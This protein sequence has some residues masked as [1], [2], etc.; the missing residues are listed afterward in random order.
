MKYLLFIIVIIPYFI[1]AQTKVEGIIEI[2]DSVLSNATIIVKTINNEIIT[3]DVSDEDGKFELFLKKGEY[4]IQVD[5][6][7]FKEWQKKIDLKENLNLGVI[8][9]IEDE[10]KLNEVNINARKNIIQR[11]EDKL[12]FD[13][14]KS[15]VAKAA[16]GIDV[17]KIAP[18]VFVTSDGNISLPSGNPEIYINGRK[19]NLQ[20]ESLINYLS[21][22]PSENIL[23]IEIQDNSDASSDADSNAGIINI[24]LKRIPTGF[25]TTVAVGYKYK[26]DKLDT[27]GARVFNYFGHEKWNAYINLNYDDKRDETEFEDK[28]LYTQTQ[29]LSINNSKSNRN[30]ENYGAFGGFVF[31]PN[32]KNDFGVEF[33][34]NKEK[35]DARISSNFELMKEDSLENK[36]FNESDGL[37]DNTNWYTALNY[38]HVLDSLGSNIKFTGTIGNYD[39]ENDNK[40]QISDLLS[41]E[42]QENEYNSQS[43][44]NYYIFR[45]DWEQTL[46]KEWK[47]S[48]GLKSTSISRDN[49]LFNLIGNESI[50][51]DFTGNFENQE[52]ISASYISMKKTYKKHFFKFGIRAEH[53]EIKTKNKISQE[54]V[55]NNYTDFFPNFYY[56]Y[57]FRNDKSLSFSYSRSINRP[58]FQDL[59]PFTVQENEYF[60]NTGNPNLQPSYPN[61]FQ[62]KYQ[63]KKHL[64][65]FYGIYVDDIIVSNYHLIGDNI[66]EFKPTNSGDQKVNGIYHYYG[67]YVKKWFYLSLQNSF[68]R[69]NFRTE[70]FKVNQISWDSKLYSQFNV[71]KKLS[72]ELEN[73]FVTKTKQDFNQGVSGIKT[74]LSFKQM[75]LKNKGAIK[76]KFYD[77]FNQ[78]AYNGRV[79][80]SVLEGEKQVRPVSRYVLLSFQYTFSNNKKFNRKSVEKDTETKD[81]L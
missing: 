70:G 14:T 53:S 32:S 26:T 48:F 54:K 21:N 77:I 52:Q 47:L 43:K 3:Y 10:N 57:S 34:I 66:T 18:L 27:K 59:N 81:R 31:Y 7:G 16:T 29:D 23:S 38:K 49:T 55:S 46:K 17:L 51:T 11:K 79:F 56:N 5:F 64:V 65:G 63:Y 78:S 69:Y 73:N 25:Q 67:G 41:L 74:T 6:I 22:I 61:T 2:K 36:S 40:I 33:Y 4:K 72:I 75:V 9:L 30:N 44:T 24:I 37:E 12:I 19:L 45:G 20:G 76:L 50:Q 28:L 8:K 1:F 15:P 42:N 80:Y 71:T 13:V 58:S 60:F 39:I 68:Y 35:E 62:I